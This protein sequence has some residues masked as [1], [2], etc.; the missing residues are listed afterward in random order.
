MAKTKNNKSKLIKK[1][2]NKKINKNKS[3]KYRN[4]YKGG[5]CGCDGGNGSLKIV[6]GY[7]QASY[8]P[9]PLKNFYEMTNPNDLPFP[10]IERNYSNIYT[11]GGKKNSFKKMTRKTKKNKE[12]KI[13]HGGNVLPYWMTND[14]FGNNYV[15]YTGD[16]AGAFLGKDLVNGIIDPNNYTTEGPLL[17]PEYVL[18]A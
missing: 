7:G 12:L 8:Q 3:I 1:K 14:P 18:N 5:D 11:T 2:I 6:G 10:T 17:H 4:L 9:I 15:Q 13:M 16:T